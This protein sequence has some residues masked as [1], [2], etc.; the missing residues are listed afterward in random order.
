MFPSSEC[1]FLILSKLLDILE[2]AP[3]RTRMEHKGLCWGELLG[4]LDACA[5][6]AVG[7]SS[8]AVHPAAGGLAGRSPGF[9][10][11]NHP[12][13]PVFAVIQAK[14]TSELDFQFYLNPIVS[15]FLRFLEEDSAVTHGNDVCITVTCLRAWTDE[16]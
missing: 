4:R 10:K 5:P 9:P 7:A 6:A 12:D 1:D 11:Q 15:V 14:G 8:G 2:C 16:Q 3:K 13:F